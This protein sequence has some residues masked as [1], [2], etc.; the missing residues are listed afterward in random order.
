MVQTLRKIYHAIK[1]RLIS[2]DEE[3]IR[4]HKRRQSGLIDAYMKE[5]AVRKLQIGAQSHSMSGWLNVDILPKESSV[6]YMDATQPFPFPGNTFQY[7]FTEHMI[8]HITFAEALFMLK[9]CHRLLQP[10]GRIRVATPNLRAVIN[11]LQNPHDAQH[12]AYTKFYLDR[13]CEP[14]LPPDPV[15][16][17]NTMFYQF[18]HRFI[19][20]DTSLTHLLQQAGF[21]DISFQQVGSSSNDV[22]F[23]RIEQHAYEIGEQNNLLETIVVEAVK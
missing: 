5:H 22:E 14:G 23:N 16:V 11:V 17:V 8:E 4:F 2:R 9:E 21:R 15:Y 10:G 6:V 13:F 20:T 1:Y 19:H 3:Y 12:Q 7:V 18:G